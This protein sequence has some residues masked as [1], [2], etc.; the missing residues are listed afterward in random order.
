MA[1]EPPNGRH[2]IEYFVP[3][4]S[5]LQILGPIPIENSFTTIPFFFATIKCP[6]S[7]IN[8][9]TL[10]IINAIIILIIFDILSFP[11]ILQLFLF[12]LHHKI[13]I[14]DILSNVYVV[15]VNI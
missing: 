8:T 7:C 1:H 11:P 10:K 14:N 4:F 12:Y 13:I 9:N 2:L 5:K 15:I 3:P 6:N